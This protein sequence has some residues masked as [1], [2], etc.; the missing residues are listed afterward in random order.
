MYCRRRISRRQ[1]RPSLRPTFNCRIRILKKSSPS[2]W[3]DENLESSVKLDMPGLELYIH[4]RLDTEFLLVFGFVKYIF[5][6]HTV[7]L[8][9]VQKENM[10]VH[11]LQFITAYFNVQTSIGKI[12]HRYRNNCDRISHIFLIPVSYKNTNM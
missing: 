8:I 7:I 10:I 12:M 1:E 3:S 4:F 9:F 6:S 5:N 2:G 11:C